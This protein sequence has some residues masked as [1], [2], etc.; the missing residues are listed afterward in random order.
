MTLENTLYI[1]GNRARLMVANCPSSVS[2]MVACQLSPSKAELML[3]E[4]KQFLQLSV[5]CRNSHDDCVVA[6][7]L[8]QLAVFE[9]VCAG[10]K[11]KSKRLDV[12]Y[13]FH[14]QSMNPIVQ[15]LNELGRSIHW[16]PPTVPVVSNV[17]GRLF[18][19]G[20]FKGD[21][22]GLHARQPVRF[23]EGVQSLSDTGAFDGAMCIEI[24]PHPITLPMLRNILQMADCTYLHTLQ[25]T[26]SPWVSLSE[27][28]GQLFLTRDKLDWRQVFDGEKIHMIDLPGH[29]FVTTSYAIP[30]QEASQVVPDSEDISSSSTNTGFDLLPRLL[31]SQP[32]TPERT[33]SFQTTLAILGP[34]IAG[35]NVGGSAICP[36]S[37]FHELVL[38]AAH[39]VMSPP[40]HCALVVCNMSFSSPLIYE[41]EAGATP[42]HVNLTESDDSGSAEVKITVNPVK[43]QEGTLCCTASVSTKDMQDLNRNSRKDA[44]CVKRQSQYLHNETNPLNQFQTKLLY[45]KIFTRVVTYSKEYQ[46]LTKLGVSESN[47]EGIGSFRLPTDSRTETFVSPPVFID[48]LLHAAGFI[49]N[50]GV[51]ADQVCICGHVESIHILDRDID[52]R[53]TFTVYC[54]LVDVVKGMILAD[55]YALN[56]AGEAVAI[57]RGMEFKRLR[58]SAFQSLLRYSNPVS[59]AGQTSPEEQTE[60]PEIGTPV[61]P[62]TNGSVTPTKTYH[63][64]QNIKD[65][66]KRIVYELYGP[67]E[68]ELNYSE[69]LDALGIDSMMQIE[70][71]SNIK[72]AFPGE[73]V[74]YSKLMHCGT[75]QD[76][77]ETLFQI[78]DGSSKSDDVETTNSQNA[79]KS[80]ENEISRPDPVSTTRGGS[81]QSHETQA[82]SANPVIL[83]EPH[84]RETPLCLI[85]DGSGHVS[86]YARICDAD[87]H[88]FAFFDPNIHRE[89]THISSLEQMAERYMSCLSASEVPSLIIGGVYAPCILSRRTNPVSGNDSLLLCPEQR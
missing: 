17:F 73:N 57:I 8:D 78:L 33:F 81:L 7:T 55:T 60:S 61:T 27:T 54:S 20:D 82:L 58:L 76:L 50:L 48:T 64:Q 21:Y 25:K 62:N 37:V 23:T 68:Q 87:R 9:K 83:H 31:D 51:Q 19:K 2:G 3:A 13:G 44:A 77:E 22:F 89:I 43:D 6:G 32:S 34:L 42:V 28:L 39:V 66:L 16:S 41:P 47:L 56:S 12:P 4:E 46:T 35:H 10:L 80:D 52:Y 24:G 18:D 29:P 69:P 5:A 85:H 11:V 1:V 75:L 26:R 59:D 72:R 71:A 79:T 14:S 67:S 86:M 38:E 36:A 70:I 74:D 15:P 49:A 63:P 84:N 88:I 40:E 30:F 53:D 45:E 65:N